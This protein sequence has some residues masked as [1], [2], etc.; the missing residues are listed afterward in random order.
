MNFILPIF[1]GT[2]PVPVTGG[3]GGDVTLTCE[4]EARDIYALVLSRLSKHILVC[5][6][7]ECK[8]ENSR[9]FKEGSCDVIIKDLIYS[10]AGKYL[11]RVY[12]SNDQTEILQYKLHIH[13][14]FKTSACA[15]FWISLIN[16]IANQQI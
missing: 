9:F 11:L 5:E 2:T 10:D 4:S 6:R 1:A 12:Y 15:S 8:S 7:E 13:G 3:K 14:K 16:N